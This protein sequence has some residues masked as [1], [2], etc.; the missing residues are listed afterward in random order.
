V[1]ADKIIDKAELFYPIM[2]DKIGLNQ[3]NP[4]KDGKNKKPHPKMTDLK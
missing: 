3:R 4:F 1:A 2:Y